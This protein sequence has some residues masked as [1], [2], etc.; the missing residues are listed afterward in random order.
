MCC[1]ANHTCLDNGLCRWPDNEMPGQ[2]RYIRG[3]CTDKECRQLFRVPCEYE[4]DVILTDRVAGNSGQCPQHCANG[5]LPVRSTKDRLWLTARPCLNSRRIR[6]WPRGGLSQRPILLCYKREQ[7]RVW[8]LLLTAVQRPVPVPRHGGHHC[9][10][11]WRLGLRQDAKRRYDCY[12]NVWYGQWWNGNVWWDSH[13]IAGLILFHDPGL[14]HRPRSWP[15]WRCPSGLP[16]GFG[17]HYLPQETPA[18]PVLAV[19]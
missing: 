11:H 13:T 7:R 12:G 2:M 17:I 10:C 15:R 19:R 3:S 8:G 5:A 14:G 16:L 6:R 9:H 4:F 1:W 18:S